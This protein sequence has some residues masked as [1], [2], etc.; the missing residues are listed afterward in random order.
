MSLPSVS[1][2]AV[3]ALQAYRARGERSLHDKAL[4]DRIFAQLRTLEEL[5]D[6]IGPTP[7]RHEVSEIIVYMRSRIWAFDQSKDLT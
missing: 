5:C 2:Q 3:E 7:L 4:E 6:N 1:K